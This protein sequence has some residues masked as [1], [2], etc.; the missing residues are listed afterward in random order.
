MDQAIYYYNVESTQAPILA[1]DNQGG[2]PAVARQSMPAGASA[3]LVPNETFPDLCAQ[4]V[5]NRKAIL[6]CSRDPNE[7]PHWAPYAASH[8]AIS[9]SRPMT[10]AELAAKARAA[11]AEAFIGT[12]NED[13]LNGSALQWAWDIVNDLIRL[14]NGAV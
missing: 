5:A 3:S 9:A 6:E 10:L 13:P 8:E 14:E 1:E 7:S 12:G 11:K 4:H 2:F